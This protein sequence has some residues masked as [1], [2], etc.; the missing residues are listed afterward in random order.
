MSTCNGLRSTDID[1]DA[2]QAAGQLDLRPWADAHTCGEGLSTRGECLRSSKRF[3]P[4]ADS[5][6]FPAFAS[7]PTWNECWRTAPASKPAAAAT[8]GAHSQPPSGLV[9]K[10]AL[11]RREACLRGLGS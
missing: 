1:V 8:L 7:S 2:T 3:V 5:G 11:V 9:G 4:A 10:Q 6:D